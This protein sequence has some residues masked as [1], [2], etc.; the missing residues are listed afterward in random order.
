MQ[1]LVATL[2]RVI[3]IDPS[4]HRTTDPNIVLGNIL[5][6]VFTVAT[7][8]YGP[9]GNTAL[10]HQ[11]PKWKPRPQALPWPPVVTGATDINTGPL[12]CSRA[13]NQDLVLGHISGTDI[14]LD[15]GGQLVIHISPFFITL[16]SLDPPLSPV[17]ESFHLSISAPSPQWCPTTQLQGL[18]VGSYIGGSWLITTC[19]NHKERHRAFAFPLSHALTMKSWTTLGTMVLDHLVPLGLENQ[20]GK[21]RG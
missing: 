2:A 11:G 3:H 9:C 4:Y 12:G 14:S 13:Q 16:P 8:W 6:Q 15:L 18:L 1:S 5:G 17:H 20:G 19:P 10:K 21:A 7:D